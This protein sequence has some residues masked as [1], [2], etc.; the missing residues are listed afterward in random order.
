M[1][2]GTYD[3]GTTCE[4][5]SPYTGVP[6]QSGR[7][8]SGGRTADGGSVTGV[9]RAGATAEGEDATEV[10]DAV[11]DAAE[12]NSAG[13]TTTAPSSSYFKGLTND[14]LRTVA[15]A[16]RSTLPISLAATAFLID[17]RRSCCASR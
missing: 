15:S 4:C 2:G 11:V 1:A 6:R 3:A 13:A 5:L 9:A 17:F 10:I 8:N 16:M 12:G 14:P 7:G